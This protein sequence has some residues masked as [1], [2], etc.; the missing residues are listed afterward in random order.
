MYKQTAWQIWRA[1]TVLPSVDGRGQL[2]LASKQCSRVKTSSVIILRSKIECL[3]L[4]LMFMCSVDASWHLGIMASNVLSVLYISQFRP[5]CPELGF[6][7]SYR[8]SIG[9]TVSDLKNWDMMHC[10]RVQAWDD[11][12]WPDS[13]R[14]PH[15]YKQL[16]HSQLRKIRAEQNC[17]KYFVLVFKFCFRS[18]RQGKQQVCSLYKTH[19]TQ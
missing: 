18:N 9:M 5:S 17:F 3:N 8:N 19:S 16:H 1:W 12:V 7:Y 10:N 14:R 4:T 15:S 13:W 6:H 11:K 2:S